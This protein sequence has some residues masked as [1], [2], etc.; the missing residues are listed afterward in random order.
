MSGESVKND[1]Y[2]FFMQKGHELGN[3]WEPSRFLSE[4]SSN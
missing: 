1:K 4:F 2:V 3:I